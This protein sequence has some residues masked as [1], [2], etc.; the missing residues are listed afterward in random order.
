MLNLIAQATTQ[1]SGGVKHF[2]YFWSNVSW[3][4]LT[5]GT[6]A[7]FV[8]AN[9]ALAKV[10]EFGASML[11]TWF[12]WQ[13]AAQQERDRIKLAILKAQLERD[14]LSTK[15]QKLAQAS[16]FSQIEVTPQLEADINAMAEEKKT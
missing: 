6:T 15:V 9:F 13:S 14:E 12:G 7:A 8:F 3:V 5:L 1:S 11:A 2:F 16:P 10:K 4:G